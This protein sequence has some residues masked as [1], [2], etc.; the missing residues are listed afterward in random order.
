MKGLGVSAGHGSE[1][2]LADAGSVRP[3]ETLGSRTFR[4]GIECRNSKLHMIQEQL[5][6][7]ES[8][9][10]SAVPIVLS[11]AELNRPSHPV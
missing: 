1:G 2:V 5:E 11:E 4:R 3:K 6:K 7:R 8:R 10:R 9:G